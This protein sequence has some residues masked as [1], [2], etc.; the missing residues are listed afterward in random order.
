MV[1]SLTLTFVGAVPKLVLCQSSDHCSFAY[2]WPVVSGPRWYLR[3]ILGSFLDNTGVST[4]EDVGID[5]FFLL[6]GFLSV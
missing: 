6:D 5:I 4:A 3:T 2:T 1:G